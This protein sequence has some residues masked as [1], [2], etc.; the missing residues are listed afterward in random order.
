MK[1]VRIAPPEGYEVDEEK[2]TF[3]NIVFKKK[4]IK[5]PKTWEELERVSGYFINGSSQIVEAKNV[6]TI[7]GNEFTFPTKEEAEASVALAQLCQLRDRYNNG[8]KPDWN[9]TTQKYV[10]RFHENAI[11]RETSRR[12]RAVLSFKSKELLDLFVENFK[13]LLETAKPFL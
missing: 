7:R 2:S 1:E 3:E 11:S 9:G 6:R 4:E 12:Y 8:W 5:L 10:I 13:D